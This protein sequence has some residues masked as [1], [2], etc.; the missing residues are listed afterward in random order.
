MLL[1]QILT[2][3]MQVLKNQKNDN[4]SPSDFKII[5]KAW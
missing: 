5:R 4:N 2:L 1:V 3:S